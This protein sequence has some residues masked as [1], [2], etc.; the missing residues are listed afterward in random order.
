M[1]NCS[2]VFKKWNEGELQSFLIEIT[3]EIFLRKD[4]ETDNGCC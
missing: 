3:S 2:D 1:M 4:D